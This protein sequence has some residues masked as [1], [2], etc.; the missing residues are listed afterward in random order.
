MTDDVLADRCLG[1][2]GTLDRQV[3]FQQSGMK[4]LNESAE[5]MNE[6][7][8]NPYDVSPA[9]PES[10]EISPLTPSQPAKPRVW[11]SF[12]VLVLSMGCWVGASF[13]MM[14]LAVIVVH[15]VPTQEMV[16]DWPGTMKGV[17][18]SRVGLLMIIV[19][20]QAF[21]VLPALFAAWLSPV[22]LKERLGL[23]RGHWP[24]WVW[25][26]AILA[27][28]VVGFISSSIV[29]L[30]PGESESLEQMSE[31]FREHRDFMIPLAMLIG[32]TPAFCEEILFRGY[33]QTRLVKSWG[34]LAAILVASAAF[35][36]AHLDFKHALAVFPL[37]VFLGLVSWRSGSLLP[38]MAAH[39]F[40]NC[41]GVLLM[42]LAP[43]NVEKVQQMSPEEIAQDPS[44]VALSLIILGAVVCGLPSLV[45][46]IWAMVAYRM[47]EPVV[48]SEIPP[49]AAMTSAE[50]HPSALNDH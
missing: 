19:A 39:F 14:S 3:C 28:P 35:A 40:N 47:P 45:A 21:L 7:S 18:Q 9:T 6:P 22:P 31:M 8:L 24:L 34:P 25:V 29:N 46:S 5:S 27:T 30:I 16:D 20:P 43:E 23:V 17:F 49:T 4:A 11:T 37:G 41:L 50:D 2:G 48:D 42:V 12:A 38:A 15:G 36:A 33:I 10:Q 32:L 13:A 26:V 1:I 44:L